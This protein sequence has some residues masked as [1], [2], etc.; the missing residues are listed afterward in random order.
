MLTN[1]TVQG[2]LM[3]SVTFCHALQRCRPYNC[4]YRS[5]GGNGPTNGG[6]LPWFN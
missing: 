5:H 1:P 4:V 6:S 3:G 2:F